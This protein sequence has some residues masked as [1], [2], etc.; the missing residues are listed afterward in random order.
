MIVVISKDWQV[1]QSLSAFDDRTTYEQ[2]DDRVLGIDD[3]PTFLF[4]DGNTLWVKNRDSVRLEISEYVT[5][6]CRPF[7]QSTV[8]WCEH[9]ANGSACP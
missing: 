9:N 8:E 7:N 2:L 4:Q 5:K 1:L 6:F 3:V